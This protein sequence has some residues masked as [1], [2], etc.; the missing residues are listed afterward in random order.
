MHTLKSYT[1]A[2]QTLECQKTTEAA[3]AF[4]DHLD[5]GVINKNLG[6]SEKIIAA[7]SMIS[8]VLNDVEGYSRHDSSVSHWIIC[9]GGGV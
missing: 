1:R 9:A 6:I 4:L 5:V 3:E 2:Q 7:I 8:S